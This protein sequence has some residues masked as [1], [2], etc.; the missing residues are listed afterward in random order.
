M[1]YICNYLHDRW[2][3]LLHT[4]GSKGFPL[5]ISETGIFSAVMLPPW[6]S[7]F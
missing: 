5:R 1:R 3:S 2:M 7:A 6:L 4:S